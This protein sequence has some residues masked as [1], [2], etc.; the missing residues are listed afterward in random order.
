M[1]DTCTLT[2][3]SRHILIRLPNWVGDVCMCLPVLSMFDR[4]GLNYT[5]CARAWAE[6]LLVELPKAGF[7]SMEGKLLGDTTKVRNWAKRHPD[8]RRALVFPDSLSSAMVFKIAGLKSVGYRDDGRSLLLSY[9]ISK[10]SNTKHAAQCWF[11]LAKDALKIWGLPAEEHVVPR[12]TFLPLSENHRS[13]ATRAMAQHHLLAGKFVLIAPTATGLHRGQIKVWPYFETLTQALIQDGFRVIMCPPPKERDAA[14]LAAP[15]AELIDSLTLG[16]FA[17][18]AQQ[19]AVAICND[20]GASHIAA[21]AH[22]KQITIFGV[23][24]PE[25]TRPWT[26]QSSNLGQNGSWPTAQEVID[27][28]KSCL[29]H[30][31]S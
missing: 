11:D 18:L 29:S 7:I 27:E 6:D 8:W 15:S 13:L 14:K 16:G 10:G 31:T 5:L 2:S 26:Q 19:A 1:E 23:T 12:Q 30:I 21:A 25:R 28:A 17:A 20:S 4:L 3:S 24:N 9:P 22:A